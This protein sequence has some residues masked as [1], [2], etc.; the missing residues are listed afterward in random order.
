MTE[1]KRPGGLTALAVINFIFCGLGVL[2]FFSLTMLLFR[3]KIPG[4]EARQQ[5]QEAVDL[6]GGEQMVIL[7]GCL[8]IVSTILLLLAGIGY[9][10]QK[11]V[12]GRYIG[13]FYG[14]YGVIVTVAA[15]F[16]QVGEAGGGF[17]LMTVFGLIYPV[18][19]LI[20]LNTIFRDDL[21]N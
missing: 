4:E 15:T 1:G 16:S 17:T 7:F 9:I 13:S 2:E 20:L 14:C 11:R 10:K 19:T 3:D 18:L 21:V 12:M 6:M 5:M 8:S